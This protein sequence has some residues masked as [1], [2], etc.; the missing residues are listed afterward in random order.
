MSLQTLPVTEELVRYIIAHGVAETPAMVQLR[1]DTAKLANAQM[2]I[3]SE[4]G[5]FMRVLIELIGATRAIEVGTFTGYSALAVATALPEDGTLICCDI[6]DEHASMARAAWQTAGVAH[7]IDLR[8]APGARTL[9]ALIDDGHAGAFDFAFVDADKPGYGAYF[10]LL[11][12]LVRPGGVITFDNT[13]AAGRVVDLT[14]QTEYAAAIR[15]FN[16][17][18][19]QDDRVTSCIVP[20]GDGFTMAV[21]R[22]RDPGRGAK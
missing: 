12:Q 16:D 14:N 3:S 20:I 15:A 11:M 6:S 9:Q 1:A 2:Q 21:K 10:D 5:Q 19:A 22:R 18:V 13:L 17:T 4:Q 8:I 7:K